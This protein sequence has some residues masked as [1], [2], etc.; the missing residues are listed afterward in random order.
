MFGPTKNCNFIKNMRHNY[1]KKLKKKIIEDFFSFRS[2]NMIQIYS[3]N[4]LY[5]LIHLFSLKLCLPS[6]SV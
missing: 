1:V 3:S 2:S 4:L 6:F 5:Y